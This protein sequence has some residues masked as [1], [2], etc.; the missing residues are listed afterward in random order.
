[1]RNR[2]ENIIYLF[3]DGVAERLRPGVRHASPAWRIGCAPR[4]CRRK[5]TRRGIPVDD[6]AKREVIPTQLFQQ[7]A[8]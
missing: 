1:M 2:S 3:V 7:T 4:R 6:H 5:G 8:P